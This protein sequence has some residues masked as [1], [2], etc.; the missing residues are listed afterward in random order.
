MT[1]SPHRIAVDLSKPLAQ[2]PETGHNRWHPAIPP[3]LRVEPGEQVV[4]ETRDAFD[5]QVTTATTADQVA[6]LNLDVVHP[7]TGPVYV[8]GAEPGDLLEVRLLR[9]EPAAFGYT[10]QVPGFGFL[11]DV[12]PDPFIVKWQIADG[13]ATSPDLP[14]VRVPNFVVSAFLPLDIFVA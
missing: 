3:A 9:V 5:G 13:Y 8:D 11:R 6:Q 7:L 12:F 4:L 10:V 14:G 1:A 2:Q